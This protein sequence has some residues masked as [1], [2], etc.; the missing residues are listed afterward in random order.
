[1]YIIIHR[2]T[3]EVGGSCV[4]INSSTT[5]LLCDF[6]FPLSFEFGEDMDSVLPE[7]LYSDITRG[8]KKIDAVLLSHAHLDHFGLM[9][10]L[11]SHIPVYMGAATSRQVQFIDRFT[12]HKIGHF[13]SMPFYDRKG[14]HIGDIEITPYLVNHAALDSYGFLIVADGK[15]LF[16][17]GDFRGHGRNEARFEGL[18]SD[19]PKVNVLLMEGTLIGD[20]LEESVPPESEIEKQMVDLC[21]ETKGAVFVS[22]PSMNIDRIITL[23]RAGRLTGRKFIIDLHSAELFG[24]LKDYSDEIPQPSWPDVLLWYPWI[25]RERYFQQG[26]GWVMRK[27]RKW[28]KPLS[29]F[30]SEIPKSV[31]MLR[32]PFRKE[33]ENNADL[34]NSVWVYSMW[35][36]YLE[37][38]EPLKH[39]QQWTKVHGIPFVFL[40]TS[41]HAKLS[42]LKRLA[43]AL[44]PQAETSAHGKAAS[45][46]GGT[47]GSRQRPYCN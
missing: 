7:P 32:P 6:G 13:H 18:L 33:I 30:S 4:E 44:S 41:G 37:R 25:Q 34:S 29:D 23:Y 38:S 2:G 14:F 12:P 28:K 20:R 47:A 10:K 16:Y 1:M 35:K 42:D 21:Q 8:H 45:S 3:R 17:T 26:M 36:G 19:L 22:V 11:P 40:H 15:S 27:Y 9:G 31:M 43:E 24:Q 46:S 39:L 5:T